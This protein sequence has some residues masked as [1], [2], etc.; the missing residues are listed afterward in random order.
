MD[1]HTVGQTTIV[2]AITDPELLDQ[3][4]A[5]T[6]VVGVEPLV[7][8]DVNLLRRHWPSASMLLI[9]VDQAARI[10]A[11]GLPRRAEVYLVAGEQ[12]S[13]AQAQQWSIRLGAAVISL[14]ASAGFLSEALA[15]VGGTARAVG[16]LVCVVGGS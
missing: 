2:V 16:R 6:A 3:V 8:S 11:M 7:L 10:A 13:A 15:A 9:G 1:S 4:L 5:V 14:P 12:A